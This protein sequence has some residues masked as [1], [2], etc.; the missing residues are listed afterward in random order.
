M[1]TLYAEFAI[2]RLMFNINLLCKVNVRYMVLLI[3]L[4]LHNLMASCVH[5]FRFA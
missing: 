1:M 4:H 5:N 3:I 2:I